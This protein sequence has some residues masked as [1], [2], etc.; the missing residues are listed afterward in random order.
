[1]FTYYLKMAFRNQWKD[2]FYTL[3]NLSELVIAITTV[4]L[5]ANYV[6]FEFSYDKIHSNNE[7][8]FRVESQFYENE[9]L[10]DDWATSAFGYGSAMKKEI[11]GIEEVVRIGMRNT[12]QIVK[13]KDELNRETGIAYSEPSFF[14][15]FDFKLKQGVKSEQ[16]KR[17]NTVVIT[18]GVANRIFNG[19]NP[20]GKIMTFAL[21][22]NFVNCEVTG[23]M[24]NFPDNSHIKLNYL[25]SYNTLPTW[26]QD[27]WYVHEAYTYV[28][29]QQGVKPV[30]IEREFVKISEKYKT[31]DVLKNKKWAIQLVPIT[32]I[33]LNPL[34]QYEREVKG[35]RSSLYI[36][37]IGAIMILLMACVNY[38]NITISRSAE[39]AKDMGVRRVFGVTGAQLTQQSFIESALITLQAS[40]ISYILY[41]IFTPLFSEIIGRNI[42]NIMGFK[43]LFIVFSAIFIGIFAGKLYSIIMVNKVKSSVVLKG[44]FSHRSQSNSLRKSLVV[45]QYS[46]TIILIFSTLLVY[47]QVKFMQSKDLGVNIDKTVVLKYPVVRNN[48]DE[49][50]VAFAKK[51]KTNTAIKSVSISG[52][53][54]G[55][56]V[57]YYASNKMVGQEKNEYSLYEMLTVDENFVNTFNLQLL[58]GNL[59]REKANLS[60]EILVNEEALKLINIVNPQDAIGKQ[61]LLEG[62]KEP[63]TIIGVVKNWH[64]RSLSN[65]YTPIVFLQNGH[66]NWIPPKYI[67]LK[68]YGN[69]YENII[70]QTKTLWQ[71]YFPEASYDYFF[72]DEFFNRQYNAD[73][74]FG[75]I[76]LYFTI[77]SIIVALLGLWTLTHYLLSKKV[78]EVGI[79][80]IHGATVKQIVWLF[81]KEIVGLILIS[82]IISVPFSLFIIDDWL[83]AF[84]FRT[85]I[86]LYIFLAGSIF[87]FFIA[88]STVSW[89]TWLAANRNPIEA[90]RY[91]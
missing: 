48:V 45:F 72:L 85:Q 39:K 12:E 2:R 27:F 35:N 10:T 38:I 60:N 69:D 61:M 88:L 23:V 3:V 47:K 71:K 68:L 82:I 79:R 40:A 26:L 1:M 41:L 59:F 84:A 56:E 28:L 55:M 64:Q 70:S 20:I 90:L 87:A 5:L 33:H 52:A 51:L 74:K 76:I 15:V 46:I 42:P 67:S 86:E 73:L 66:I 57:A 63:S 81:S 21:G 53:V 19:E 34:K 37:I 80:K 8:I 18:E 4:L 43:W 32:D 91:E 62:N 11:K 78:K 7:Q 65:P 36:L 9:A 25:I 31:A 75:R 54:P 89:Q 44:N 58:A 49:N 16:L 77:L 30:E 24:Q 17:P 14:K 22:T 29:L 6:L 13:Y 50:V 83:S